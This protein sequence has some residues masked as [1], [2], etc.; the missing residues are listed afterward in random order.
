[1]DSRSCR[2]LPKIC[3]TSAGAQG[4]WGGK[5]LHACP[6]LAE[7]ETLKQTQ[8]LLSLW[9]FRAIFATLKV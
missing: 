7:A 8:K 2:F 5:R 3:Q 9:K 4:V 6:P 1:M